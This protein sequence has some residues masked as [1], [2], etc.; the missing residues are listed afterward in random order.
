LAVQ[1]RVFEV[2]GMHCAGCSSAVERSLNELE[3]VEASVSLPAESA[4]VSFDPERVL[5]ADLA[6]AV[7]G[8]GYRLRSHTTDDVGPAERERD[9]AER[10]EARLEQAKW[11]MIVS[12]ALA[13]PIAVWMLPEMLFHVLWPSPLAFD[14]G[15]LLLSLPVL[16]GP[17]RETMVGGLM[18]LRRF[19]P[20][21]DSLI[22]LGSGAA[23]VTGFVA[24]AHRYGLAP[25]IMSYAGVGAMIMAIHLTGRYIE[26]RARGRSSAAISRLLS[27]EARTAHVE[28]DGVEVEVP[29]RDVKVGDV[30]VVRPGEKIPTDGEVIEGE[31][32]V[33]ESLATGESMPVDKGQGDA[34]IGATINRQG[35]LRVKA[36]RVGRETFLSQVIRLVEEAQGSKIPIQA[37]ADRVTAVF[38]PIVLGIAALTLV[39]WLVFPAALRAVV[40]WASAFVPWMQPSLEPVSLASSRR[41][42]CW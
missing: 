34:V 36:T 7:L 18:A 38:V 29:T 22:A 1:T 13:A 3:G 37:F 11:R 16:A 6:D 42:P 39:A 33:D 9:Q 14:L 30:M 23:V 17:G 21:M 15:I 8:A 5:F 32:S 27:L 35:V 24:V 31:S 19:R 40:S 10:R 2:E 20:N 12:W 26:T 25:P 4:T 28:R 41:S